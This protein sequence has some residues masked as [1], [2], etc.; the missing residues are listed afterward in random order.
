MNAWPTLREWWQFA[1]TMALEL[2]IVFVVA[3]LVALRLHS[4]SWRRA[5]WQMF[6]VA[7]LL[8]TVGELSGVRN[9]LRAPQQTVQT[10]RQRKVIVTI[11]DAD[12]ALFNEADFVASAPGNAEPEPGR[13]QWQQH[14]RWPA[15]IWLIVAAPL[16]GR[17]LLAQWLALAMRFFSRR[18][19]DETT[20]AKARRLAGTMGISRQFVLL[21]SK[22]A[23]APFTF[24]VWK[25]AIVL[26][27]D[28]SA[29][30]TSEQQDVALAHELAHVAGFDSAWRAFSQ[31]TCAILWWHPLVWPAKHELDHASELVADESS[32]LLADGPDRLA[33]CL[34]A[35]AKQLRRPALAGW[36]GMDGGGFRSSLGKRVARLLQLHANREITR[37]VPWYLRLLAPVVCTGLVWMGATALTKPNAGGAGA[38]SKSI[39]GTAFAAAAHPSTEVKAPAT[40]STTVSPEVARLIQNGKLFYET[41]RMEAARTNLQAALMLDPQNPGGAYYLDLVQAYESAANV[42]K[43]EG[44]PATNAPFTDLARKAIYEKLRATRFAE[45]GPIDNLPLS[46]VLRALNDDVRHRDPER[47]GV[48]FMINGAP[49]DPNVLDA[50]GLPVAPVDLG[51]TTIRLSTKLRDVSCVEILNIIASIADRPIQY[52]VETYGVVFTPKSNPRPRQPLQTRFFRIDPATL[53]Q[54]LNSMRPPITGKSDSRAGDPPTRGGARRGQT[55]QTNGGISFLSEV[56]PA[57]SVLPAVRKWFTSLGVDLSVPDKAV[58]FNDRLGALMVR[59]TTEDLDTIENGIQMLNMEPPQLTI[60]VKVIEVQRDEKGRLGDLFLG[61]IL[62]GTGG[63][64]TTQGDS[65]PPGSEN[66]ANPSGAFPGPAR[67]NDLTR[68]GLR[69]VAPLESRLA[70]SLT[71]EQMRTNAPLTPTVTGI[72]TDAQFRTVL[73]ALE[74]R[75]G[76]DLMSAPEITTQSRRQAQIKVVDIKYIVTDLDI[77]E[78]EPKKPASIAERR[79]PFKSEVTNAPV[80]MGDSHSIVQSIAEPFELGPVVDIIPTVQPDGRTIQMTVIP[81]LQEFLGYDDPGAFVAE[82]GGETNKVT[83]PV[84]LPKFRVR[85]VQTSAVVRDGQ[86]LVIGAGSARHLQQKQ[87]PDGTTTNTFV[88]KELFYFVTPTLIDAA[89]N[90]LHAE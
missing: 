70:K 19:T 43:V 56:V 34:L 26:P 83:S 88:E 5:V 41:G 35:C 73:K 8:V 67:G 30:F 46:E 51:S 76:T 21:T 45:Y 71:A 54:S 79:K 62:T 49:S 87:N 18:I 40:S 50:A 60:R 61:S 80:A 13:F 16:L 48:N 25:P 2:A 28:F 14:A 42:L 55:N 17:F 39:L 29:A 37:R 47:K 52:M 27:Q 69:N 11:K 75:G 10:G 81:S 53:M 44:T 78:K 20:N 84:P 65:T 74:Q 89:G 1:G 58:F 33:E 86:T 31:F 66:T 64:T 3:K 24:G 9:W 7:M 32:L 6:M 4:A 57:E 23:I 36:L 22:R 63:S 90:R 15:I 68:D 82:V 85:K 12:P 59:A 38:W 72:L 77:T